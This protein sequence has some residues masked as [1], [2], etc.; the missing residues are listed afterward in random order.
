M[1][2][3]VFT[4]INAFAQTASFDV[5]TYQTPEFFTKNEL[6]SG[7]QFAM[8]AV[9]GNFCTITLYKSRQAKE[10]AMK[11]ISRQWKDQVVKRLAKASKKPGKIM[12]GQLLDG[13]ASTLAIGNFYQNERKCVVMLNSFGKD[14]ASACV[15]FAFS[16]P[17]FKSAVQ[18]FS[19]NL[20]LTNQ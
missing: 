7:L 5:F 17:L 12:T 16:D 8:N 1:G 4:T 13:W 11:D 2:L 10:D 3:V 20:H 18:N 19:Q 14:Q 15:V 6:P 9:D